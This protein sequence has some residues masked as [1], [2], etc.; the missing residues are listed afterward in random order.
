[1]FGNREYQKKIV[2]F[3]DDFESGIIGEVPEV[4]DPKIGIWDWNKTPIVEIC[5]LKKI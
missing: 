3:S 4:N 5:G 2:I 1:L